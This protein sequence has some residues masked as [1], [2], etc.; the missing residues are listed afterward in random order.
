MDIAAGPIAEHE[1]ALTRLT[2][3][4]DRA[5]AFARFI[6]A[7]RVS[8]FKVSGEP[9]F[10]PACVPFFLDHLARASAYVEF[11]A[12]GSSVLAARAGKRIV[13]VESDPW[14]MRAVQARIDELG[15]ANTA[16]QH[17]IHADI[18]TTEAW[19]APLIR[20]VTAPRLERW[21]R[22]PHAPWAT[23]EALPGPYLVLVD[24]RFRVA[25]A[26]A[27]AKFLRGKDGVV[28]LDDYLGRAHYAAVERHME[29][30]AQVGRMAALAPRADM[31][32]AAL[33]ADLRDFEADW[34]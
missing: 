18:G 25:C 30:R 16:Q 20:T 22:Y 4:V 14:F 17:F 32:L 26:L 12:G 33:D 21:R 23:I 19:G 1:T 11:G 2:K 24:G 13:S 10:E 27:A 29:I 15:I 3:K 5:I 34:R 31:D 28:L 9:E 8:G 6:Y 7:Q